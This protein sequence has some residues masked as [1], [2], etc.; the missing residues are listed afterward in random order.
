M[1]NKFL[2]IVCIQLILIGTFSTTQ[3]QTGV[4]SLNGGSSSQSN[5]TYAATITNQS[6]VYVLNSGVLTLANCTLTKTGDASNVDNSS[7]YGVN[8]GLLV[9]SAGNVSITGSSI[10]TN[11]SGANGMFATGTNSTIVMTGGSI[12]ASG[13][14]A[15]GVDV[16]YGGSITLNNVN[17]TTHSDNSSAIATDFGGGTVTVNGGTILT[18]ATASGS[19]SAGIY[20]TGIITVNDANVTSTAD[21]GGVIDGANSI[22]INNTSLKGKTEGIMIWKTFPGSGNATVTMTGGSLTTSEGDAFYFNGGTGNSA[23]GTVTVKNG[24]SISTGTGNLINA[25]S[26]ANATFIVENS[27]LSGNIISTGSSTIST[28]LRNTAF[29]TGSINNSNTATLVILTMDCSSIWTVTATS[30]INGLIT[31]PCISG[32]SVSN[33]IGNGN[34]VYYNPSTNPA[35]GGL[36]FSLVSGGFLLPE[37]SVGVTDVSGSEFQITTL[38]NPFSN[39]VQ[40]SIRLNQNSDIKLVMT[41]I[42]GQ[43][44]NSETF[45]NQFSGIFESKLSLLDNL[46]PGVYLLQ[47]QIINKEGTY[48]QTKKLLKR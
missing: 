11:A 17:V 24:A 40:L 27:N 23:S 33:I 18:A 2:K 5:Q 13:T 9:T 1:S 30:H 7:Q 38:P 28:T 6:A 4:Y 25:V 10:T 44:V 12:D 19:H 36:T 3:C 41:D 15:H 42:L 20:S 47:V 48:L 8:A 14:S 29:L 21:A 22:I 35:L 39:E 37:G 46:Q 31:N 45:N 32:S 43:V 26:P 34:N 16:T